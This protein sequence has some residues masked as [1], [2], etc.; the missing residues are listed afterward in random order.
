MS[1][2]TPIQEKDQ[3]PSNLGEDDSENT[4][5]RT[6]KE[7]SRLISGSSII[8][9]ANIIIS[10]S[11]FILAGILIHK[12]PN[13]V[14]GLTRTLQRII[15][16]SAVIGLK[17]I[18]NALTVHLSTKKVKEEKISNMIIGSLFFSALFGLIVGAIIFVVLKFVVQGS[19]DVI[20]YLYDWQLLLGLLLV[21]PTTFGVSAMN[22]SLLGLKKVK[23][24]SI[25]V[26]IQ[27]IG[28][29]VFS[30]IFVYAGLGMF[31]IILGLCIGNVVSL[32]YSFIILKQYIF[33]FFKRGKFFRNMKESIGSIGFIISFSSPISIA[34]IC[35]QLIE[36]V[37]IFVILFYFQGAHIAYVQLAYFNYAIMLV[38]ASR[39][40]QD[41]IGRMLLPHLRTL[42]GDEAKTQL[43]NAI[44]L[45]LFITIPICLIISVFAKEIL[46][47]LALIIRSNG[48]WLDNGQVII[49]TLLQLLILGGFLSSSYYLLMSSTIPLGHPGI[50][51]KVEFTGLLGFIFLNFYFIPAFGTKGIAYVFCIV[52][53]FMLIYGLYNMI[54][55]RLIH[56]KTILEILGVSLL[57]S[58]AI[59]LVYFFP[60]LHILWRVLI[61]VGCLAL[62]FIFVIRIRKHDLV[63]GK[64]LFKRIFGIGKSKNNLVSSLQEKKD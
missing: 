49:T 13:Y 3:E 23:E 58:G 55:N 32:I 25:A 39:I 10:L 60:A 42:E 19:I 6:V 36:A 20:G 45:M 21:F 28:T 62:C 2:S 44:R 16:I 52:Y 57:V 48:F 24:N 63:M 22:S 11:G 46:L 15:A 12:M 8:F 47:L 31:S 51:A 64:N 7:T 56:T 40:P 50:M 14:Y 9:L 4:E 59:V 61:A 35:S 26:S 30:I 33:N 29:L 43:H 54:I 53:A 37:M 18:G 41:S 38:I 1:N 17:G 27:T 5:T 34:S